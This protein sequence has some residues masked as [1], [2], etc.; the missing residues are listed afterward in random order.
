MNCCQHSTDQTKI[1][2]HLFF[3]MEEKSL[4][5][6]GDNSVLY[7][8]GEEWLYNVHILECN[9][10]YMGKNKD[11]L[12]KC[13][14]MQVIPSKGKKKSILCAE[15]ESAPAVLSY[16]VRGRQLGKGQKTDIHNASN[17]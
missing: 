13:N 1:D 17:C 8:R 2:L 10:L 5:D 14:N 16:F 3:L 11:P 12:C 7:L 9:L 15:S 4:N 6:R